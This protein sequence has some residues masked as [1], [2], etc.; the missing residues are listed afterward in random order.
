[1]I[2]PNADLC[3]A[4]I[5]ESIDAYVQTGRPTGDFLHAVLANDLMEA[6]GRA[7]V[8]NLEALPHICAYLYNDVPASCHGSYDTVKD[9]LERKRRE[10]EAKQAAPSA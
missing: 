8:Y 9:W 1:M 7:D 2:Y 4:D 5:R 10:W 3:P 6:V